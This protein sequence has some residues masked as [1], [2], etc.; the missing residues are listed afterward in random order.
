MTRLDH[1]A[2]IMVAAGLSSRFGPDDKLLA[3][4][5]GAPLL[6]WSLKPLFEAAPGQLVVV[7]GANE[8]AVRGL[9]SDH[10]VTFANNP[11]PAAGLG[12]SI[13]IGA[14]AVQKQIEGVFIC[15]G[16]M[17]LVSP[18]VF[19]ELAGALAADKATDAV[20]PIYNSRRGHP[21]LFHRRHLTALKN[22]SGD[23][24]A[25]QILNAPGF[26]L[27]CLE[28]NDEG[29]V[30]DVDLREDLSSPAMKRLLRGE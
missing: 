23:D 16:D 28:T 21:V 26:H 27:R 18:G 24:G 3:E 22:L 6:A 30:T 13:A 17:P 5:N 20:A 2:A 19:R 8:K 29:A 14:A 4:V 11:D 12:A 15:L 25:K 10:A 9:C 1:Y 7:T